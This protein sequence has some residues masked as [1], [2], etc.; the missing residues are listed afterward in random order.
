M[1]NKIQKISQCIAKRNIAKRMS[2]RVVASAMA[3]VLCLSTLGTAS[4]AEAAGLTKPKLAVKK[5]TLY[6]NKKSKKTYT[7][8]VK[9]NKVKKIV[10]TTWKTSKKSVIS[11]TKKK[12]MSVKLTAKK[13]GT[14]TVTATVQYVPK[15]KWM[16][17]TVNLKCKVTSK[18]STTGTA[19]STPAPKNT[20]APDEKVSRVELDRDKVVFTSTQEG[21]N[22]ETLAA[23]AKNAQGTV[24]TDEDITWSTDN[25]SVAEVDDGVVTAKKEGTANITASV[26][27]VK[28]SPCTVVVDTTAPAIE[29][30]RITDY[31]TITVYFDE[32]V[33]GNPEVSVMLSDEAVRMTPELAEDGKSLKLTSA[34]A[35]AEGSYDLVVE[36][37]KDHVGNEL[38]DGRK[39]VIKQGSKA[40]RF[41][42]RTGEIP[43]GQDEVSVYYYVVDQ[44]G[45]EMKGCDLSDLDAEAKT[46]SGMPLTSR[47]DTARNCV[48]L[49]GTINMLAKGKKILITLS[50]EKLGLSDELTTVL[51]DADGVGKAARIERI[52]TSE[53][54]GETPEFTLSAEG[55]NTFTLQAELTD[56]FGGPVSED[57]I[58]AIKGGKSIAEFV[59]GDGNGSQTFGAKSDTEVTVRAKGKGLLTITAYLASDD[60]LNKDIT[61]KINPTKLTGI[62]VG[63]LAPGYNMQE[64][65]AK[66]TLEPLGTGLTAKDL[67]YEFAND[68]SKDRAKGI[69]FKDAEDGSIYVCVTAD[70]DGKSTPVE[71]TVYYEDAEGNKVAESSKSVYRS[72]PMPV[73]DSISIK[74]FDKDVP[75]GNTIETSYELLNRFGEDI[76]ETEELGKLT[77]KN[78]SEISV[79]TAQG[80]TLSIRGMNTG[81]GA[82]EAVA[83]VTLKYGSSISAS[84][85]V[86][87]KAAARLSK[88][89]FTEQLVEYIEGEAIRGQVYYIPVTFYDQY[90]GIYD[91]RKSEAEALKKLLDGKTTDEDSAITFS[92]GKSVGSE[93]YKPALI[94]DDKI[95]AIGIEFKSSPTA[96]SKWTVALESANP[97]VIPGTLSI[98]ILAP[99]RAEKLKLTDSSKSAVPG[100]DV[101]NEFTVTDQYGDRMAWDKVKDSVKVQVK[102][103]DGNVMPDT[104]GPAQFV[105]E[106]DCVSKVVLN[107][108]GEYVVTVYVDGNKSGL[109]SSSVQD[110]YTLK[111]ANATNLIKTIE[112][113]DE[114]TVTE[115]EGD[116][117]DTVDLSK[118]E[119]IYVGK[120][121]TASLTFSYKAYDV[122]GNEVVLD[123]DTIQNGEFI[124]S[125]SGP[126]VTAKAIPDENDT[127]KCKVTI[128]HTGSAKTGSITVSLR[129]V[130]LN[131]SVDKI[132]NMSSEDSKPE[133][134]TY[135][136]VVPDSLS[137]KQPSDKDQ[138]VDTAA[139]AVNEILV[140]TQYKIT[141]RDQYGKLMYVVDEL[142]AVYAEDPEVA[143]V[144]RESDGFTVEVISTTEKTTEIHVLLA[145]GETLTFAVKGRK[146][147]EEQDVTRD[148]GSKATGFAGYYNQKAGSNLKVDDGKC[149]FSIS[150]LNGVADNA[151]KDIESICLGDEN[152]SKE[153]IKISVGNN[154]FLDVPDWK[155]SSDNKNLLISYVFVALHNTDADGNMIFTVN[156]KDGSKSAAVLTV[157]GMTDDLSLSNVKTQKLNKDATVKVEKDDDIPKVTMTL[158]QGSMTG[159]N[160]MVLFSFNST[161]STYT[162]DENTYY[163]TKRIYDDDVNKVSYGFT[164]AEGKNGELGYYPSRYGA[165]SY[166]TTQYS[167][168]TADR[169]GVVDITIEEEDEVKDDSTGTTAS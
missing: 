76:T 142:S 36:G 154:N 159:W 41:V 123:K 147:F 122:D 19:T 8:K 128:E 150:V 44:Y 119:C 55:L 111:I 110:S 30:A 101:T 118:V 3:A 28:S 6:Y 161:D 21:E 52:I 130:R 42:C 25:D 79:I 32:T 60:S 74:P 151:L 18:K 40:T 24:L 120:S 108:I 106:A 65:Q 113:S 56:K 80:G 155:C 77:T 23:V 143:S 17:R 37:L 73:V 5:K 75:A 68:A 13:K 85:D 92:Y 116:N 20:A 94:S 61:I 168:A 53:G 156:F 136:I 100:V 105:C 16:V 169:H 2:R 14:A 104:G 166:R 82:E 78:T 93:D 124:W 132:I 72:T 96:N 99:R 91:L 88:I 9:S 51:V 58:Y 152:L 4:P 121:T 22:T 57:V 33:S 84:V 69:Q 139:G 125:V 149:Y 162:I 153:P 48:V 114:V 15:G 107:E 164:K 31:K 126:N 34:S 63:E 163:F 64:S 146:V 62:I 1:R 148:W 131:V 165:K 135:G 89:C 59:D 134:G 133:A 141:A 129:Y 95:E 35:L 45:E 46:E 47:V 112:I 140:K 127:R 87:V 12:K 81:N 27:N 157:D 102:K 7:L 137:N 38:A 26:E 11:I 54:D 70:A 160:H 71:F 67:K 97:D 50:S 98:S 66:V 167:V 117:N 10:S 109:T 144:K 83:T 103:K 86:T 49:S 39:T 29:G 145:T 43:A 138:P 90:G 115:T 158:L